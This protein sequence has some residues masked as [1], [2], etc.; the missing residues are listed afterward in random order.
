MA[1]SREVLDKSSSA[2]PETHRICNVVP[3]R[4][5]DKD[6]AYRRGNSG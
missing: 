5:T 2:R 6:W 1:K 4:N 3:S